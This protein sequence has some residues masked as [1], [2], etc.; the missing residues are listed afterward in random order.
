MTQNRNVDGV[1]EGRGMTPAEFRVVREF[2]G[3]TGGW[4]AEHVGVSPNTVE[5]WEQGEERIPA[6][7]RGA[8]GDLGRLTGE[9]VAEVVN[10]LVDLPEPGIV[11]YRDDAEYHAAHPESGYPAAWHRAVVARVA[12]EIP[13]L[14]IAY[15]SDVVSEDVKVSAE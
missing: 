10:S 14:S 11:T 12:Q 8:L 6:A 3:L 5:R 15:A 13:G 7:V 2:L 4:L 1:P 9:F